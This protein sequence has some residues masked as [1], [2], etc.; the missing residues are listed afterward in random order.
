MVI[1]IILKSTVLE[2]IIYKEHILYV[3]VEHITFGTGFGGISD[4][5]IGPTDGFLYVLS[6]NDGVIYKVV[7]SL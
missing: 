1:Y 5:K 6:I 3:V 7:P 2:H 4:I